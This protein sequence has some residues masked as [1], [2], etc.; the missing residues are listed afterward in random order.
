MSLIYHS[1]PGIDVLFIR[2]LSDSLEKNKKSQSSENKP[3]SI[4]DD[5]DDRDWLLFPSPSHLYDDIEDFA[6]IWK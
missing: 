4:N 5:D 3:F 6:V 2:G 1:Q